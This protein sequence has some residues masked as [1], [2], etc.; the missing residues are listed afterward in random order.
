MAYI[1]TWNAAF[2]ASPAAGDN[3]SEGDD[4]IRDFKTAIRERVG[5]DHYFELAGTDA[6]Q[7]EHSKV[8]FN[9]PLAAD[10]SN[11][12]D[13]GF[14]Y[15][16]DVDSVAE[17]H[18]LDEDGNV[19]QITSEGGLNADHTPVNYTAADDK[20]SSHLSGIDDELPN[21]TVEYGCKISN[22]GAD[23]EHDLDISV[24]SRLAASLDV[25]ITL[26][27]A[28]TKR[29]DVAWAAGTGDGGFP[30][31]ITLSASTWYHVFLIKDVANGNVDAGFDTSITAANLLSD[32]SDY[33]KYKRIGSILTD[34][35]KNIVQFVQKGNVF[36]WKSPVMDQNAAL[37]DASAHL[38]AIS[39]PLGVNVN[40]LLRASHSLA[41]VYDLLSCP[42]LDDEAPSITTAPMWNVSG[43]QSLELDVE[44]NTSSQ[45]R[46]RSTVGSETLRIVTLGWIDPAGR[47][48]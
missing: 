31:G 46:A 11:V 22:N 45:I 8:T 27:S 19:F 23:Q 1:D 39:V 18:W 44:T 47:A 3:I 32:A 38:I 41:G 25:R 17:F 40:A 15:T 42:D 7:G 4:K 30:T 26:E 14:L 24:G 36:Y 2:E 6:D 37:G 20:V 34:T 10:P 48:E 5:K 21:I 35:S 28:L 12:A 13:K 29:I 9:A 43:G 33:T 16:K